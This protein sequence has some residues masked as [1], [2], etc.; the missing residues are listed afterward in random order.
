MSLLIFL[1]KISLPPV[2]VAGMSLAARRFGPTIG[3]LLVGL[4][5]MTGPV[6]LFLALDKGEAF[7]LQACVGIE[8]AVLGMG[9]FLLGYGAMTSVARWPACLAVAAAA[10]G[11]VGL[12]SPLLEI[13]LPG[14]AILAAATLIGT[15]VL[16]PRPQAAPRG[17]TLP[18]WDIP[19][20]MAST[21]VLVAIIMLSADA[22]GGRRSGIIASYPVIVTVIGSFTYHQWGRDA[23]LRILRGA[24]LSLLGFVGFFLAVGLAMP[25]IGLVP[26][27]LAGVATTLTISATSLGL[28]VWLLRRRAHSA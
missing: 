19:A 11:I 6:L 28:N 20:R 3:G 2:L 10:Y 14:A 25:V 9:A 26:A 7:A 16:L 24:T 5:W 8:L 1:L 23:V 21:L 12:L 17:G 4:P 13:E 15:Y 18:R 27:F 22:I